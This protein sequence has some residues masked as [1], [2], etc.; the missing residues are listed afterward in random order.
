MSE[1]PDELLTGLLRHAASDATVEYSA[2]RVNAFIRALSLS[3]WHKYREI[4]EI[5][6]ITKN[7][8]ISQMRLNHP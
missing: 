4:N 6:D 7:D 5:L 3:I 1:S 2:I 8:T